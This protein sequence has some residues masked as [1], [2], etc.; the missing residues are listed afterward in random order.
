GRQGQE[1]ADLRSADQLL[2]P[3]LRGRQE[4]RL[5][6]CVHRAVLHHALQV[7]RLAKP[8][9]RST[10]PETN[11][12]ES[13]P[14][15]QDH[16]S[17]G[18]FLIRVFEFVS[19]FELRIS[20]LLACRASELGTDRGEDPCDPSLRRWPWR[21]RCP[22]PSAPP[23]SAFPTTRPFTPSSSWTATRV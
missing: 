3:H 20:D 23:N 13:N 15:T 22:C 16:A 12:N 5:Q 6:G 8:E 9:I 14:K 2:G 19:D 7:V 21:P 1:M 4:D 17:L 18:T 10:K 11:P